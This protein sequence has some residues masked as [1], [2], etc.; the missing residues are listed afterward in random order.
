MTFRDLFNIR[1]MFS[2]LVERGHL[3]L[4]QAMIDYFS[5]LGGKKNDEKINED[6]K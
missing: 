1:R 4:P 5:R 6:N 3:V 2:M